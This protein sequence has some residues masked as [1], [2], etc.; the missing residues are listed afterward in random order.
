M[1]KFNADGFTAGCTPT[2]TP[3]LSPPAPK[4]KGEEGEAEEES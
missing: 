4:K 1:F 3:D 2:K